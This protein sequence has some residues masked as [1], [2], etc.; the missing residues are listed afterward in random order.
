VETRLLFAGTSNVGL[1]KDNKVENLLPQRCCEKALFY[2]LRFR[3]E[4]KR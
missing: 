4:C 3:R 1:L 2:H